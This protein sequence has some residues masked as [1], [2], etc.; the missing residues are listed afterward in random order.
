MPSNMPPDRKTR[1][2]VWH[3]VRRLL[4]ALAAVYL[5]IVCALWYWQASFI[6]QP[7]P[8]VNTTPSDLGVKFEKVVLPIGGGHVTG[9]WVPS[10][11]PQAA[12]LLYSHGNA[13]NVGANA[14]E[15]VRF[16]RAGF[17]VLIYDYRGYGESTGGPP[18]EK[19]AY[20]DAERAW[21]YL[22]SE[23]RIAPAAIVI[24]GHSLGGVVAI[25]LASKHPDAGA[26]ITEST[27]TSIADLAD[28]MG[29]GRLL[30][31]RL[32][33]TERFDAL[34]RIRAVHVPTLILQGQEDTKHLAM[35]QRLYEAA[36]DPK[37][38]AV[39]PGGGHEDSAEVN[40][41]AYFAALNG[42]LTQYHLRPGATT[43]R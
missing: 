6:F 22:V 13:N 39:I 9:W 20:E 5:L 24:Y 35:G 43:A 15:V 1:P 18:R 16:Q 14:Q 19:L 10:Q 23:R 37:Q 36:N 40:P 29:V 34:S 41:I 17:N 27:L 2:L 4:V 11:D 3:L 7:S 42:F 38:R 30:P 12:T 31:V 33:L 28:G 32:M 8:D 25:D 26:L 21:T